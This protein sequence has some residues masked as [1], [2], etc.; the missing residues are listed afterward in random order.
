MRQFKELEIDRHR[1]QIASVVEPSKDDAF[2]DV[3]NESYGKTLYPLL[4]AGF[5]W[6]RDGTPSFLS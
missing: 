2:R 1:I 3:R 4:T 5:L 6:N